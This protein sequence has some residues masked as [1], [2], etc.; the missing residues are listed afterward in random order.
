MASTLT[1]TFVLLPVFLFVL[2][3]AVDVEAVMTRERCNRRNSPDPRHLACQCNPRFNLGSTWH[4]YYYY[5]NEKM[6]CVEGAEE[7]NWNSFFSRDRCLALCRGT[8]AAAR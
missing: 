1:L 8:S 7:D 4:N 3:G 6:T 5:D 2:Q